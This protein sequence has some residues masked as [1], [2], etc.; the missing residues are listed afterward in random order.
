MR[1]QSLVP[2]LGRYPWQRM[3]SMPVPVSETVK[4]ATCHLESPS[5]FEIH[6][7]S[8]DLSSSCPFLAPPFLSLTAVFL[9]K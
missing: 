4:I 9:L 3:G 8:H 6:L 1:I 2:T 7:A 5:P